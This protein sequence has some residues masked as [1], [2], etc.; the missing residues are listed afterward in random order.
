MRIFKDLELVEQLGSGVP[1]ILE[2]YNRDC[3]NFLDNFTRMSFKS[4]IA[5]TEITPQVTPQV[6]LLKVILNEMTRD[7]IQ[8]ALSLKDRE[9]FRKEYLHPALNEGLTEM[10]IPDKPK[11]SKQKYRLTAKGKKARG[12]G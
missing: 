7:Q 5:T 9:H 3:F 1:R 8:S 6:E 11:S 4:A 12:K 10:T 2:A